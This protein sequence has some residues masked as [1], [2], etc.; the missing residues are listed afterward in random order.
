MVVYVENIK[1]VR[2]YKKL[3]KLVGYREKEERII[4]KALENTLFSISAYDE[5]EIVGYGRIIGDESMFLYIQDLMVSPEYQKQ[6]IGTN[7]MYKLLDQI[8]E[9]KEKNPNIQVAIESGFMKEGFFKKFGFKTR[10]EIRLGDEMI[11]KEES[12]TLL[13]DWE[14]EID[15]EDLERIVDILNHDG[16]I[17]FP[18]DTVYGL[19]C[20]CFSERAINKIFEIKQRAKYK[21]I[22]VLT[23]SVEKMY[24]VINNINPIEKRIMAKYFPGAVTIIFDKNEK[25]PDILTAGLDTI[26]VRIP[27]NKIALTILSRIDYP[28]ATTSANI[29][30]E[31]D[32]IQ[33]K[34]FITTFDGKVDAIIDGGASPLKKASTIVRVEDNKVKILREGTIKIEDL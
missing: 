14:E 15:E 10:K 29:S 25:T 11:L 33:V 31:D 3:S 24:Q 9:Y 8:K 12:E 13:L 1:N 2:E 21:P 4:E 23:N 27:N 32:G 19:A 16:I 30:G 22:N 6:K 17:I 28:L 18:T 5:G 26:G 7:I 20:N 34:D